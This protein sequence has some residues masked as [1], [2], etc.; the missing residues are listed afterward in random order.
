MTY[1]FINVSR[2]NNTFSVDLPKLKIPKTSCD[3]K[4]KNINY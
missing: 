4:I 2:V 3:I 1:Y